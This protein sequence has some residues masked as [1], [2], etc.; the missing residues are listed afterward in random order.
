MS[1]ILLRS[2]VLFIEVDAKALN[3]LKTTSIHNAVRMVESCADKPD[4]GRTGKEANIAGRR[5]Y[6]EAGT[7][8][9][10]SMFPAAAN[11]L[12]I[13]VARPAPAPRKSHQRPTSRLPNNR[14]RQAYRG[15]KSSVKYKVAASKLPGEIVACQAT[16]SH[17]A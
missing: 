7:G 12:G 2:E 5:D 13:I 15:Q 4:Q 17:S 9:T 6:G 10:A 1:G 8:C 3:P 14:R 16:S 11:A